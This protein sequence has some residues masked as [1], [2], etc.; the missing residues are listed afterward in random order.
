MGKGQIKTFTFQQ[1]IWLRAACICVFAYFRTCLFKSE[2]SQQIGLFKARC[3]FIVKRGVYLCICVF[4]Y[5]SFQTRTFSTKCAVF[6]LFR[7]Q[8]SSPPGELSSRKMI[9]IQI[10]SYNKP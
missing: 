9:A 4:S 3:V 7:I 5:L 10:V 2:L 8:P 1:I 6:C